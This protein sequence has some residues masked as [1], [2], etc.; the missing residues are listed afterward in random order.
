MM[1]VTA[2]RTEKTLLQA[3]DG[4]AASAP[5][6]GYSL[7]EIMERLDEQ[8]FGAALFVLAL[9]CCIPFLYIVP[10]IVALPMMVL[11]AQMVIGR[12][13][14]WL[15]ERFAKRMIDREGLTKT[16]AGGRKWFG[17]V[18]WM[19]RPPAP[20]GITWESKLKFVLHWLCQPRLRWL[21]SR[22]MQPLIG[23][24]LVVFCASILLP[25]PSTNTVPGFGVAIASAGLIQRHG[26]LT[27]AG[28]LIGSA[29]IM[30]L[31]SAIALGI[32]TITG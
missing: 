13:E 16:A 32:R 23:I 19:M 8:A 26:V 27:L 28:L 11:A 30:F 31:V 10:Q 5:E 18:D 9:P 20:A 4:L 1:T 3:I 12:S 29:W 6:E 2:M 21:T 7:G 17:W 15:P 25:I 14:P 24:F 22:A